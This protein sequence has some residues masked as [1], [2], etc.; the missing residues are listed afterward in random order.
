MADVKISALTAASS[1]ATTD[2]FVINQGGTS[3]KATLA[4]INAF[5][6]PVRAA[7]TSAQ[8]AGFA[9]DT[10][11][12]AS[13]IVLPQARMQAGT[14][15]RLRIVVTKTNAGTA[16]PVFTLRTG[17]AGTTADTS[18]LA[19]TGVAQTAAIDT[20]FIEILATFRAVGASA[21]LAA[22]LRFDHD[23]ASTGFAN[24]TR[25]FQ[26]QAVSA[27]FDSTTASMGIGLSINGGTNAAWT[28]Q[29]CIPELLNLAD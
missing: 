20:G 6:D 27:A 8:G 5:T 24:A 23:L 25:G 28:I 21:V 1:L 16:T 14:Y 10:Y 22:W 19:Y 18:R 3:K 26:G 17:T 29:Q 2:E 12:T 4:Q 9:S 13:R 15:Y 11:V 7:A